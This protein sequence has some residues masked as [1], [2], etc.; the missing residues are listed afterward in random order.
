MGIK[1]KIKNNLKD[2]ILPFVIAVVV[3][4]IFLV[5]VFSIDI[6]E[7]TRKNMIGRA[8]RIL[9][10]LPFVLIAI[11]AGKEEALKEIKEKQKDTAM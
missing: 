4:I 11:K 8:S 1:D 10:F 3:F 2:I 5:V 7:T 9:I 6:D